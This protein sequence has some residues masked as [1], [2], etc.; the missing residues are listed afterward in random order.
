[1]CFSVAQS[2]VLRRGVLLRAAWLCLH[3]TALFGYSSRIELAWVILHHIPFSRIKMSRGCP[4]KAVSPIGQDDTHHDKRTGEVFPDH[5]TDPEGDKEQF[6]RTF[7]FPQDLLWDVLGKK[8]RWGKGGIEA[9]GEEQACNKGII[10]VGGV[11]MDCWVACLSG[12][13]LHIHDQCSL[14]CLLIKL[15]F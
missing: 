3:D 5:L 6:M 10:R 11:Y 7:E 9:V 4:R 12:C 14:A 8:Q 1:M 15:H 2:S 13:A